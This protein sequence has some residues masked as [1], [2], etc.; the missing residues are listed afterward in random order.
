[1]LQ[2]IA[3]S[4][5]EAQRFVRMGRGVALIANLPRVGPVRFV[6]LYGWTNGEKDAEAR[7]STQQLAE[8]LCREMEGDA[9]LPWV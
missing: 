6:S 3:V 9:R 8:A 7:S 5:P 2:H 4:D 1:M